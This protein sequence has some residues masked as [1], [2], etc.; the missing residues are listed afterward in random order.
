MQHPTFCLIVLATLATA[1]GGPTAAPTAITT[2]TAPDPAPTASTSDGPRIGEGPLNF[3]PGPSI[4]ITVGETIRDTAKPE[5]LC[6]FD[7]KHAC[8]RFTVTVPV[9]GRL[10]AFLTWDRAAFGFDP[11]R[12]GEV[13]IIQPTGQ[14]PWVTSMAG[15]FE[16]SSY[17]TVEANRTYQVIVIAW[18]HL[19][20]PFELRTVLLP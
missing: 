2:P 9:S 15:K 20:F 1:C 3:R 12:A 4:P 18:E 19:T 11:S 6:I 14:F 16:N 17:M 5:A 13:M 7:D 10:E 8:Q